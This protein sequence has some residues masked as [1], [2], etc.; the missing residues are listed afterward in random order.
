MENVETPDDTTIKIL[1]P[2]KNMKDR[3]KDKLNINMSKKQKKT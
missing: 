3:Y 1:F 2:P